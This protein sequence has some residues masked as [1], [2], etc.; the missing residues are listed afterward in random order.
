MAGEDCIPVN[1]AAVV[2][3]DVGGNWTITDNFSLI[4]DFGPSQ[5]PQG[6]QGV[7]IIKAENFNQVC[8]VGRPDTG[9]RFVF[10]YMKAGG[11]VILPKVPSTI[12]E[13]KKPPIIHPGDPVEK[14]PQEKLPQ[15]IIK[16]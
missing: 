14:L 11:S 10:V 6:D 16:K 15:P 5:K 8:Y 7:A 3:K 12:F 1:P 13:M 2:N 4:F 9:G